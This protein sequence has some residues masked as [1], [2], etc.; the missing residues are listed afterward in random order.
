VA[1]AHNKFGLSQRFEA[2]NTLPFH[3]KRAMVNGGTREELIE[4]ITHLAFYG[5]WPVAN[6]ALPIAKRVFDEAAV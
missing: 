1:A 2:A 4:T 6:S 3:L 5:G